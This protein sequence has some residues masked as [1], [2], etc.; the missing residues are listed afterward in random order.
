VQ[1]IRRRTIRGMN[2]F[3]STAGAPAHRSRARLQ[4][5]RTQ[6]TCLETVC[7]TLFW[8]R[9]ASIIP[10]PDSCKTLGK[11]EES[12]PCAL[13]TKTQ[14]DSRGATPFIYCGR[15][16]TVGGYVSSVK[17]CTLSGS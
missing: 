2:S 9:M 11:I 8:F 15:N 1:H 12:T 7:N 3:G 6:G 14:P 4:A 13:S 5:D 16:R 10:C 17:K